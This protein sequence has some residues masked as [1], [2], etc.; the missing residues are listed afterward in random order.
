MPTTSKATSTVL[1]IKKKQLQYNV[2]DL[3]Q[4]L[5]FLL[6]NFVP[7]FEDKKFDIHT[8][9]KNTLFPYIVKNN[10]ENVQILN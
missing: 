4:T 3:V 6:K 10:Y 5:N 9:F 1:S 8:V 7:L 2:P